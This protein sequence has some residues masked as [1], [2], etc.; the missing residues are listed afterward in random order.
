MEQSSRFLIHAVQSDHPH[1]R[2]LQ[3]SALYRKPRLE[4]GPL[5]L[6]FLRVTAQ[7]ITVLKNICFPVHYCYAVRT[8]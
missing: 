7:R 4:I 2:Y 8:M 5:D 1:H 6:A 3:L